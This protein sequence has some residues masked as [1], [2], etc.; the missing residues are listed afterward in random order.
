MKAQIDDNTL[1]QFE[2]L[3]YEYC[4]DSPIYGLEFIK[5][6]LNDKTQDTIPQTKKQT[7]FDWFGLSDLCI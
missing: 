1:H 3:L 4:N 7:E 2:T 6:E 5:D